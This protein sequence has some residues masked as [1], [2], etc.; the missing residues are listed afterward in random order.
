VG[1]ENRQRAKGARTKLNQAHQHE[2]S[3]GQ[4]PNERKA[5]VAR[6]LLGAVRAEL[7]RICA[8]DA[9]LDELG[10]VPPEE[11]VQR[12]GAADD[13]ECELEGESGGVERDEAAASE[14]C[15]EPGKRS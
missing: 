15:A 13:E 10:A 6:R 7:D 1:N 3:N 14:K 4:A 2:S 5:L 11:E 9:L 12:N 8:T